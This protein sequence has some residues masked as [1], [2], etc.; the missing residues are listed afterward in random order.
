MKLPSPDDPVAWKAR[1]LI[2]LD[3]GRTHELHAEINRVDAGLALVTTEFPAGSQDPLEALQMEQVLKTPADALARLR[4]LETRLSSAG[5][6]WR[7]DAADMAWTKVDPGAM[8]SFDMRA[9]EFDLPEGG[10]RIRFHH[11]HASG[12]DRLFVSMPRR[13]VEGRHVLADLA[14]EFPKIDAAEVNVLHARLAPQLLQ[15]RLVQEHIDLPRRGFRKLVEPAQYES[16]FGS[17]W[18]DAARETFQHATSLLLGRARPAVKEPP[19][20]VASLTEEI[21]RVLRSAAVADA[22]RHFLTES[23]ARELL[24]GGEFLI[25]RWVNQR[26]RRADHRDQWRLSLVE[27]SLLVRW[28]LDTGRQHLVDEEGSKLVRMARV[29]VR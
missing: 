5:P 6:Y 18:R 13:D 11:F 24:R 26:R 2:Y 3:E 20:G 9:H 29:P 10:G 16:A 23:E 4:D 12:K 19:R 15:S 17:G 7:A 27:A 14:F 22:F 28:A 1:H 21:D 8:P 25:R